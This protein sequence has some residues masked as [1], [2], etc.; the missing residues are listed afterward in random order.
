MLPRRLVPWQ[1]VACAGLSCALLGSGGG[2]AA[3]RAAQQPGKKNLNVLTVGTP[4]T[5]VIAELG[6]PVFSEERDGHEIDVFTFKQGYS[7]PTK[8]G[9]AMA[10]AAADV[11]TWGL[12]EVVGTPVEMLADGTDVK[13][14]ISYDQQHAVEN[15]DIISG[16]EVIQ[17]RPKF[18]QRPFRKSTTAQV[19][20]SS[21]RSG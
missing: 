4:R 20:D 16:R 8:A 17:P 10:H 7:K 14:E 15:V 9:R 13:L 18:W 5:H 19:D 11:V 6:A 12:W 2:C 21:E 1:I 3:Y